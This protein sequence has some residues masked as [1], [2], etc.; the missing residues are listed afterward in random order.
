[1]KLYFSPGACSLSPHIALR[2][3]GL[4]FELEQVDLA[5]KKTKSGGDLAAVNPK[6]YVPVLQLDNGEL[7]TEAAVIAQYIADKAAETKL[8]PAAGTMERYRVQEWLNYVASEVHKGLGQLFNPKMPDDFKKT[9]KEALLPPRFDFLSKKLDGK[10]Y[11]TGDTFTAADAYLFTVLNWTGF[12]GIDL[13]KW[14]VL[15]AYQARVAARPAV[16][17]AMKAEGLQ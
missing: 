8:V 3:A 1:M 16:Q 10:T 2:E 11:L 17:A 4:P 14:P 6:N 7:L 13:S 12:L 5:T 15:Q 9:V